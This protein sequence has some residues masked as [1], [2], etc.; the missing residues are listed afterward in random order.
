MAVLID[1]ILNVHEHIFISE[2]QVNVTF[3]HVHVT[4]FNAGLK[5]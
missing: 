5:Y 3:P 4:F 1:L 2:E